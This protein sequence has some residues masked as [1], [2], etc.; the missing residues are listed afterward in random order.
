MWYWHFMVMLLGVR[1]IV[2]IDFSQYPSFEG[3][4]ENFSLLPTQGFCNDNYSFSM[5]NKKYLLRK[6]K[7]QSIDRKNE[8]KIQNYAYEKEIAAKP[9]L[10]DEEN[11]L[12]ICEF[13]NGHHKEVLDKDDLRN[14]A[15]LLKKLHAIESDVEVLSVVDVLDNKSKLVLEALDTLK[16]YE[17][18]YV[19]CHNDLNPKNILFSKDV[20]LIDW[21]FASINDKYFDLASLCVEFS[22][23]EKEETYFLETYFLKKTEIERKKLNAYKTIYIALCK[24]WFEK[25]KI[26]TPS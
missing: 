13:L 15:N 18:E 17:R 8:F 4:I 7:E 23:D 26:N 3:K 21:E 24:Q 2:D 19:L 1:L 12:M 10:I 16:N 22:L 20:K 9:I 5:N 14:V 25:L 11:G 6:F